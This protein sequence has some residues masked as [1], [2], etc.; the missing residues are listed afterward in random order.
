AG[1]IDDVR[2][3]ARALTATDAAALANPHVTVA[4]TAGNDVWTIRINSTGDAYEFVVNN[5]I[6]FTRP[7]DTVGTIDMSGGGGDDTLTIDLT[8]GDPL[9]F[10]G[11]SFDGGDGND[12]LQ[13][14]GAGSAVPVLADASHLWRGNLAAGSLTRANVE[15]VMVAGG[16]LNATADLGGTYLAV[17]AAAVALLAGPVTHLARL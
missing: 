5:S 1:A 11:L 12:T 14:L 7:L 8:N 3:Y 13:V 4:T 10:Y 17:G 6:A 2:V 9:P 15:T 16:T